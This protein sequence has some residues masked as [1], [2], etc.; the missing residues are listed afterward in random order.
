MNKITVPMLALIVILAGLVAV[1]RPTPDAGAQDSTA[2]LA[3]HPLVG[4]WLLDI[5]AED[6]EN[7]PSLAIFSSDGTY[8]EVDVDGTGIGVWDATGERAANLT[9]LF[10][11]EGGSYKVRAAVEVD[12]TG[13]Q[14]SA[15]YTF[16]PTIA[17]ENLGE[18]GP[19]SATGTRI[20]VEA[21]GEPV[22][23]SD[24]LEAM[25]EGAEGTPEA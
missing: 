18:F 14:L 12:E 24:E 19:E 15:S 8:L 25:F 17:G 23:S 10:S 21:M 6:P 16:E 4:A 1:G 7:A 13:E 5:N 9:I 11:D 22:G 20:A 2:S 3:S